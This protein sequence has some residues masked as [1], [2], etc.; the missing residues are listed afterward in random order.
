MPPAV[1]EAANCIVAATARTLPRSAFAHAGSL[2]CIAGTGSWSCCLMEHIS[3]A[4]PAAH[5]LD[6]SHCCFP[7]AVA[8][9]DPET[10]LLEHLCLEVACFRCSLFCNGPL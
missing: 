8:Y 10:V 6:V 2:G 9:E 5:F 7:L 3:N 4:V 1:I